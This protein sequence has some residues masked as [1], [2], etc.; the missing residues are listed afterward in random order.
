MKPG[1]LI[2]GAAHGA[3]IAA[4]IFGLPWLSPRDREPVSVTSVSF[5]TDAEFEAAQSAASAPPGGGE[6]VLP[7]EVA[8][9]PP[10]PVITPPERP[11]ETPAPAPSDAP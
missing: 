3:L 5:V 6:V 9:E 7:P 2:S 8:E 11:A 1:T 4:A 10:L